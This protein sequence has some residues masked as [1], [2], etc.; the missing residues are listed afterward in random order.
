MTSRDPASG[1]HLDHPSY[2]VNSGGAD[3]FFPIDFHVLRDLH[4]FFAQRV[5]RSGRVRYNASVVKS[6]EFLR[7]HADAPQTATRSGYNPLFE[8]F[9]NTSFFLVECE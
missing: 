6:G 1:A 4:R 9:Q 2:V 5:D 8:D 7:A 3:I